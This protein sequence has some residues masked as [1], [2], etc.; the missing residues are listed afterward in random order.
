MIRA[1]LLEQ[2][3]DV[4]HVNA[5]G[6]AMSTVQ[7]STGRIITS[8]I[9]LS[10]G[11]TMRMNGMKKDEL[12]QSL[13]NSEGCRRSMIFAASAMTPYSQLAY[14][15]FP[16]CMYYVGFVHMKFPEQLQDETGK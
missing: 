9:A 6:T 1:P 15:S 13:S 8:S 16:V 5:L 4:Q 10:G 3:I 12:M 2:R 11:A 14:L 7:E